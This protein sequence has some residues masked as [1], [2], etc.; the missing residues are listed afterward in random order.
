MFIFFICF[1]EKYGT[2]EQA[3]KWAIDAGYRYFDTSSV[4]LNEAE[5][6]NAIR[7]KIIDGTIKRNEICIVNKL[8]CT[9][10]A[11]ERVIDAARESLQRLGIEYFDI[12]LMHIPS[13]YHY[14]GEEDL[15]PLYSEPKIRMN[16]DYVETWKSMEQLVGLG[17][18]KNV[19]VSNCNIEQLTRIISTAEMYIPAIN[20][21]ECCP[22]LHQKE[23]FQFCKNSN[24]TVTAYCPLGRPDFRVFAENYNMDKRIQEMCVKYKKT[25]SQLILRYLVSKIFVCLNF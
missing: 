4:Y 24:I 6:G 2:I 8:C 19:G 25:S 22:G 1:K 5:I 21:I 12:Y 11:P 23:L 15:F 16:I 9:F 3:V 18:T 7:A 17:I 20:H 14:S 10:S 13:Q